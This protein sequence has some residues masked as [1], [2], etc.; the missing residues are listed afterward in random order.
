MELKD[1]KDGT[2]YKKVRNSHNLEIIM[3][4]KYWGDGEVI[5][6]DTRNGAEIMAKVNGTTLINVSDIQVGRRR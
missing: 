5:V 1:I 6:V 2:N 3:T 4:K